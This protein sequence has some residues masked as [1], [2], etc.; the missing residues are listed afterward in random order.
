MQEQAICY[1]EVK[2]FVIPLSYTQNLAILHDDRPSIVD[3]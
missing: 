3:E 1:A 2:M